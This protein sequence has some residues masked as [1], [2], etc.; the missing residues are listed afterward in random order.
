MK[1]NILIFTATYNELKN[2]KLYFDEIYK[3]NI[4]FDLLVIDDN[5]PDL[6]WKKL[7]EFQKKYKNLKVIIR[8]KT[9]GLVT[10]HK[11]DLL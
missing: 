5:S 9:L 8:E 3:I 11:K 6:T 1:K 10:E 7:K 2:L 4:D